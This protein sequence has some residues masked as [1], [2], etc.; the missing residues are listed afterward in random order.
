MTP[1]GKLVRAFGDPD[2]MARLYAP[3]IAWSLSAALVAYPRPMQ[4]R[5][6]VLAFNRHVWEEVYHPDCTVEI[7]DETGDE[8]RSAVRFIY[9]A[10]LRADGR[11]YRNE[12]TLFA[13]SGPNGVTEVFEGLDT[14]ALLDF[15][16]GRPTGA[17]FE[18][19]GVARHAS[20]NAG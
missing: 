14:A 9:S 8:A 10:R 13:R 11:T 12:Y 15:V 5:E 20:R 19:L 1:A 16:K 3:D 4:G 2:R 17:E 18:A 6:A 7:L